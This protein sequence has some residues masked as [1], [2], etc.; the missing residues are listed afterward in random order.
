[1]A[2]GTSPDSPAMLLGQL[3]LEITRG[4]GAL[5]LVLSSKSWTCFWVPEQKNHIII[6][7]QNGFGLKGKLKPP[8]FQILPWTAHPAWLS[9]SPGM[10]HSQ[11]S[12]QLC[13][14]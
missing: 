2:E 1:M 8:K 9:A 14:P 10:G 7:S 3:M 5:S 4:S 13:Q 12:G 11:L 6:E